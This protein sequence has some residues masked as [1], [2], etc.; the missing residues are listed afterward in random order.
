MNINFSKLSKIEKEKY[1]RLC[2]MP[3]F[4]KA[5]P[6]L[7]KVVERIYNDVIN[8]DNLAAEDESNMSVFEKFYSRIQGEEYLSNLASVVETQIGS[9]LEENG[10]TVNMDDI[11]EGLSEGNKKALALLD[12]IS[13]KILRKEIDIDK[14]FDELATDIKWD[15]SKSYRVLTEPEY[16]II[17]VILGSKLENAKTL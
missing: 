8:D 2:E 16:G 10:N 9:Y 11:L 5:G 7:H 17:N 15:I 3:E 14:G 1:S 4:K 6:I 12:E 13:N